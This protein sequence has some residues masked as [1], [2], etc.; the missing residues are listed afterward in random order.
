MEMSAKVNGISSQMEK[1]YAR[2]HAGCESMWLKTLVVFCNERKLQ[3]QNVKL[4]LSQ[5]T[6]VGE[7]TL[8]RERKTPARF[9]ITGN[10]EC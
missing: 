5:T 9:E 7:P 3:Q 1:F 8:P 4:W 6:D 2:S 10:A